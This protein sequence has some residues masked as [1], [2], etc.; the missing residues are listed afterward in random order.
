M[1]TN[2]HNRLGFHY[3]PDEAHYAPQDL[4]FWL[5]QLQA[6]GA[7]WLVL[8]AG[9]E[10][11]I[12]EA[13]IRG[14]LEA[15]IEPVVWIHAPV[16]S[17]RAKDLAPALNAYHRWGAQYVVPGDR[18][19]Q[20]LSWSAGD[21]SRSGLV[22]RSVDRLLPLWQLQRAI[23]L[24]PIFPPLEPGGDYWD[25]AFLETA[26]RALM[27]RGQH[28][29]VREMSL[30]IY[31]WTFGRSLDWGAGGPGHWPGSKAYAPADN[32]PDQ[33]GI[34]LSDWYEAILSE[35]FGQA[36][37]MLVVAGGALRGAIGRKFQEEYPLQTAALY[38]VFSGADAPANV[39]CFAFYPLAT[40]TADRDA[41]FAWFDSSGEAG[42]WL[43]R[44]GAAARMTWRPCHRPAKPG[45][46]VLLGEVSAAR[47]ALRQLGGMH[48]QRPSSASSEKAYGHVTILGSEQSVPAWIEHGLRQHG[49][50]VTRVSAVGTESRSQTSESAPYHPRE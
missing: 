45:H 42:R 36:L 43:R 30:A 12:P 28:D 48:G 46:Y 22:E 4:E 19:N 37:P 39:S 21:W 16:S 49:C 15:G 13:F 11:L 33:R 7:A 29:L 31:G 24:R 40:A 26:I 25:T 9:V 18:P 34:R 5:P 3:F 32:S 27:R 47:R 41:P 1:A 20:R 8:R 6:L 14:L 35:T 50:Q 44:A 23:G 2:P 10:Q 38:R 17:L